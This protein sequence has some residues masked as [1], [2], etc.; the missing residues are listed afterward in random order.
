[1]RRVKAVSVAILLAIVSPAIAGPRAE[2][3][4]RCQA[5]KDGI[6]RRDC[7]R[8]LNG[9][10]EAAPP[11]PSVQDRG[12]DDPATTSAIDG[13]G[14][15]GQTFCADR[16][17]LAAMLVAGVLASSP[18]DVTTKGCQTI[19]EDAQVQVLERHPSPLP[20]APSGAGASSR[21]RI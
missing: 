5:T 19:P 12:R 8:S 7:F 11:V 14:A 13:P 2:E 16:D 1:M 18:D 6:Q 4:A 21:P 10:T 3:L 9:K 20:G 15:A 17:A